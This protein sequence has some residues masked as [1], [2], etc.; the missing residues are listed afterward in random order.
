M[1]D[2][3]LPRFARTTQCLPPEHG[4]LLLR[5]AARNLKLDFSGQVAVSART[6]SFPGPAVTFAA[7]RFPAKLT[8]LDSGLGALPD[9]NNAK[10][11]V[12]VWNLVK[13]KF[14]TFTF[15][16]VLSGAN[17]ARR[18]MPTEPASR[19]GPRF[20]QKKNAVTG[21]DALRVQP[22]PFFIDP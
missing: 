17:S 22:P 7:N 14:E 11:S 18:R 5:R 3:G 20:R 10:E 19:R 12:R 13:R 6:T 15:N 16:G 4:L 21:I 1:A 2:E 9:W 8:L